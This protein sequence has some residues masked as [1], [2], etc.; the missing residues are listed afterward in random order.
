MADA[1]AAAMRAALSGGMLLTYRMPRRVVGNM[2][3]G[4]SVRRHAVF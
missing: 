1:A 2:G 4:P 3:H